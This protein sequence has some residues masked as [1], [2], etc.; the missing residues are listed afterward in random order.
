MPFA[1]HVG[2]DLHTGSQAHARHLAQSRVRLLG[3]GSENTRTD[4]AA[5]G[6]TYQRRGVGLFLR[7]LPALSDQLANGRQTLF[8]P[9]VPYKQ[10]TLK[11]ATV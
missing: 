2:R 11:L 10:Q 6:T 3:R 5:L 7:F 4:P 1:R 9:V 8:L